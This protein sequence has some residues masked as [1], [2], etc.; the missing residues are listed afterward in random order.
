MLLPTPGDECRSNIQVSDNSDEPAN[1]RVDYVLGPPGAAAIRVEGRVD[2]ASAG[3][4]AAVA[5]GS[6]TTRCALAMRPR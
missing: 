2:S 6:T 3:R 4:G 1:R 5:A